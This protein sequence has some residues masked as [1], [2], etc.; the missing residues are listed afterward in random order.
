M[1]AVILDGTNNASPM[2]ASILQVLRQRLAVS[3]EFTLR[4]MTIAHCLGCFGCWVK[5]PGECVIDDAGQSVARAVARSELVVF[6]TPVT[7]GG[8]S[9]QLKK[10]VDRLIPN[11]LPYFTAIDGETHHLKRYSNYANLLAIGLQES[12]DSRSDQV[13]RR[14]VQRN[15]I[16]LHCARNDTGVIDTNVNST[17]K[18]QLLIDELLGQVGVKA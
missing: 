16:N 7:F 2:S 5:K 18:V 14:L 1:R 3:D 4:E 8:Y 6:L 17:D 12:P 9:S 15:A 10:A 11:I 13:F